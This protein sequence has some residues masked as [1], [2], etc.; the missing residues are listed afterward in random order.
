M[1]TQGKAKHSLR[2]EDKLTQCKLHS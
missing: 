2:S 1:S